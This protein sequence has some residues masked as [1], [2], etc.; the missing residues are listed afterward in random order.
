MQEARFGAAFFRRYRLRLL[1]LFIAVL[2]PLWGF[3]EIADEVREAEA[4][5]FDAPILLIA[6][7][8]AREGFD[9]V[10]LLFSQLGY[11]W[12]VVPF[13]ILLVLVL[14]IR[15]HAREALFTGVA[16]GGSAL[17][18]LA[19]KQLFAR[20][21]PSLW[22][23]IAPETTYSFPSGHAMGS[24]TLAWVCAL[25]A[26]RTPWRW[27]VAF[28]AFAFTALVG[29]SRVYLGVH[30]PSDIL[31]GWAAASVWAGC[32]F[33]LVFQHQRRPWQQQDVPTAES[34]V[35]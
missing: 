34:V 2:L 11:Q 7:R 26:W 8:M 29:L 13:D 28:A 35:R 3:A 15:R 31:A 30:Y 21:R 18:N 33:F 4:F 17:L 9:Q 27:P 10:F 24:M 20:D 5:P 14:A 25:L 1:L 19:A 12:G 16:L 23:S 22:E 6:H 32:S